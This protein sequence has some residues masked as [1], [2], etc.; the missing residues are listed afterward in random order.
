MLPIVAASM[1]Y[2]EIII[3]SSVS[4]TSNLII[5][6]LTN[7]IVVDTIT[8]NLIVEELTSNILVDK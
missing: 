3:R 1:L 2:P 5:E 4:I 7:N 6:E 8:S